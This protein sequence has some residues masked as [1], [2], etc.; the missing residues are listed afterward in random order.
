MRLIIRVDNGVN[1]ITVKIFKNST[2]RIT[3]LRV[4]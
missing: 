2:M 4:I 1:E 3:G